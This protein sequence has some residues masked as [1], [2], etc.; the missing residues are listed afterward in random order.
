[1]A[2]KELLKKYVLFFM[3]LL[4]NA[5]GV[6]FVTK[7]SL[8]A[9]PIATIPYSVSLILTN[10]SLG[11][12]VIIFNLLLVIIQCIIQRKGINKFQ[13]GLEILIAFLFG[14][15][16]DLS[17][18]CLQPFIPASYAVK[19]ISLAAG[20][21]IIACGA[22]LEVIAD[23]VMLPGDAFVSTIAKAAHKEYGEIRILSDIAMSAI[24]GIICLLCLHELSGVREGTIISALLVGNLVKACSKLINNLTTGQ[25][26]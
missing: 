25:H 4:L 7:A 8:G 6:A 17:M 21:C 26:C 2:R 19:L 16:I 11:S 13:T 18:L 12:W 9:S 22:Y 5:F 1:M 14:Y 3:G 24:A 10:M 20:C 15:I 23:V